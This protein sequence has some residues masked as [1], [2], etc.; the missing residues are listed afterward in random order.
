[1]STDRAASLLMGTPNEP[2]ATAAKSAAVHPPQ[3]SLSQNDDTG[4]K[5]LATVS[6]ET[7]VKSE[8]QN[9]WKMTLYDRAVI[10][11]L[12]RGILRSNLQD[13]D[14]TTFCPTTTWWLEENM[15]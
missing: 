8:E 3:V 14:H 4:R 1:M 2:N 11:Y 5:A 10:I 6:V 7:M 9:H 15:S 13:P 12:P